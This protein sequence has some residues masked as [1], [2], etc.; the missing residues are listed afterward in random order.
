MQILI[1]HVPHFLWP[2]FLDLLD[3]I[4]GTPSTWPIVERARQA[5]KTMRLS[6][7][8]A[9]MWR[10]ISAPQVIMFIGT[11]HQTKFILKR[12]SLYCLIHFYKRPEDVT[13]KRDEIYRQNDNLI[14][15]FWIGVE[16]IIL[17][18]NI[19]KEGRER[20]RKIIERERNRKKMEREKTERK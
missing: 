4:S 5:A 20:K 13:P 19:K 16:K 9:S 10:H 3:T 1:L 18:I 11:L 8:T 15:Y 17:T 2:I 6:W 12:P 14:F 7:D